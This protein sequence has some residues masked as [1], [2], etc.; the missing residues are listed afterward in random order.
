MHAPGCDICADLPD[1]EASTFHMACRML[2]Q[3][4]TEDGRMAAPRAWSERSK[5]VTPLPNIP[6]CFYSDF[7][8]APE[9]SAAS[10]Q[11]LRP[12]HCARSTTDASIA[13]H[14]VRSAQRVPI[15]LEPSQICN[16]DP[17]A[18]VIAPAV[19]VLFARYD[20]SES[21]TST[22][23]GACRC[24]EQGMMLFHILRRGSNWPSIEA[25][26]PRKRISEC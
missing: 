10:R 23:P 7:L 21:M 25:L 12:L 16:M 4:A 11:L 24:V 18:G 15:C 14:G 20:R 2:Q 26:H 8:I 5:R 6:D 13:Q 19:R 3:H 17:L 22:G 1:R 9:R